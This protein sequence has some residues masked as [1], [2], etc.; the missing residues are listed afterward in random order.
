[1]FADYE[2]YIRCQEKVDALY[3]VGA[4]KSQIILHS[5]LVQY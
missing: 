5:D 1:M 3:K 2:D 4:F